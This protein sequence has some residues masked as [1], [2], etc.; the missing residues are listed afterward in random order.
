MNFTEVIKVRL[1]AEMAEEIKRIAA[2]EALPLS[3]VLRRAI[4]IFLARNGPQQGRKVAAK[5]QAKK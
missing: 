2:A 3:F 5:K 4:T 1:P